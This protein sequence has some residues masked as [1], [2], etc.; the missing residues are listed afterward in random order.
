[1]F[2]DRRL[3]LCALLA[4]D[5]IRGL[6]EGRS[7][8]KHEVKSAGKTRLRTGR[9]YANVFIA[10]RSQLQHAITKHVDDLLPVYPVLRHAGAISQLASAV[11]RVVRDDKNVMS[12]V[13][14][15]SDRHKSLKAGLESPKRRRRSMYVP[16]RR[17]ISAYSN[18]STQSSASG[19]FCREA[20]ASLSNAE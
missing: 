7:S 4:L 8:R 13:T 11:W 17:Y 19:L 14:A 16:P 3:E 20:L 5:A 6:Q 15:A 9:Y 1:M 10:F 12:M 2:T 18:A